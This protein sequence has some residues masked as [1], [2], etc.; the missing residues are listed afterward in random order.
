[1]AKLHG[2]P[3]SQIL[4]GSAGDLQLPVIYSFTN[5]VLLVYDVVLALHV[6]IPSYLLRTEGGQMHS[7]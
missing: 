6:T 3:V 1:M 2:L 4:H 7:S 5:A